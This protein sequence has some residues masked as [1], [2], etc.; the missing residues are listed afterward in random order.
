MINQ[1]NQLQILSLSLFRDEFYI[2]LKNLPNML[3]D[4]FSRFFLR[5]LCENFE[6]NLPSDSLSSLEDFNWLSF[7]NF[8]GNVDFNTLTLP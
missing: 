7:T 3:K 2:D 8:F 6:V 1:S 4:F 5:L